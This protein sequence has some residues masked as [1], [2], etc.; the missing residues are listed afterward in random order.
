M[1]MLEA[2]Y[3]RRKQ[4]RLCECEG[5]PCGNRRM[6]SLL[7]GQINEQDT[8]KFMCTGDVPLTP[9]TLLSKNVSMQVRMHG[10]YEPLPV[11]HGV[12][13]KVPYAS[14]LGEMT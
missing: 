2:L 12:L 9:P 4:P 1:T 10:S 8:K 6:R 13:R 5:P 11:S 14:L 7:A 3:I